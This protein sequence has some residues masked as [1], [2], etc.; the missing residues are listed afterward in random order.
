MK[1]DKS[2]LLDRKS[3]SLNNMSK[4]NDEE[5]LHHTF[6]SNRLSV[7]FSVS[8]QGNKNQKG[9]EFPENIP[10]KPF[11][12]IL[13]VPLSSLLL[14]RSSSLCSCTF[15]LLTTTEDGERTLCKCRIQKKYSLRLPQFV[16]ADASPLIEPK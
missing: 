14:S 1:T 8:M 13:S 5:F 11:I 10:S 7:R 3:Q 16:V 4:F 15:S 6:S 2:N 12:M 9:K